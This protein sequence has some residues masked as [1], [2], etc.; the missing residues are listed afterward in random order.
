M[1]KIITRIIPYCSFILAIWF[2]I[3]FTGNICLASTE[4]P[5]KNET[6]SIKKVI[7]ACSSDSCKVSI[8]SL[9]FRKYKDNDFIH[10]R[11]YCEWI[12]QHF[13]NSKNYYTLSTVYYTKGEM[14]MQGQLFDS[15]VFCYKKALVF[16]DNQGKAKSYY[17]LGILSD[18][19]GRQE[20][21]LNY[22]KLANKYFT[23]INSS[24]NI[25][26][27]YDLI[28]AIYARRGDYETAIQYIKWKLELD[29]KTSNKRK[30]EEDNIY[31][32]F[33]YEQQNKFNLSF[34]YLHRAM[35][36]A[37][38]INDKDALIRIYENIANIFF[39]K[40][41]YKMAI[42]YHAKSLEKCGDGNY[43][44]EKA[45]IFNNLG[46]I[47]LTRG[48][49]RIAFLYIL[50]SFSI[51]KKLKDKLCLAN[52]YKNLGYFYKK[53]EKPDSAMF[54]FKLSYET[55]C[56]TRSKLDFYDVLIEIA[57]LYMF[58]RNFEQA[59]TWYM[60][61]LE[62][63]ENFNSKRDIALSKFKI[64]IYYQMRR[65]FPLAEKYYLQS[66]RDAQESKQ[67]SLIKNIADTLSNF[68][69]TKSNF[70]LAYKYLH[71]SQ[72]L[73]DSILKMDGKASMAAL[74][75]EFAFENLK[76]ENAA[77]QAL[78][79]EEIK[80]QKLFR[81]SLF[82]ISGL[83]VI[84][85]IIIF[86]N[87][88]K[89]RKDNHLLIIQ[90]NQ[91]AEKN[92]EILAKI[93]EIKIQKDEIERMSEKLHQTDQMK[94]RF[95]SNISHEIRTPLT[96]IINPLKNFIASFNGSLEQKRQL[97]VI[98][99]NA[100]R[101]HELTNQILDLQKLDS[102]NLSLSIENADI[103]SHLKGIVS[104][105]EGYCHKT[106]CTLKF[107]SQHSSICCPFDK[108]KITKILSNLL[109]N[110]FKYN[111]SGG[112]VNVLLSFGSNQLIISVQDSGV[113]IP[114]EYLN[115]IFKRYYQLGDSNV[116]HEGT[117]VGLAYVK[118]LV[119][120]M[121]GSIDINSKVNKGTIFTI[122]IPVAE[123]IINH[124]ENCEIIIKPQKQPAIDNPKYDIFTDENEEENVFVILITE[125]NEDLRNLIGDLFKVEYRVVYAK[126]GIEGTDK[127]VQYMPDI[128]ISDILMPQMD[129]LEMCSALKQNS[130]TSH[131]PIIL[132]TAKDSLESH[133]NGYQ[134]GA[135]D[136]MVKPFDST[137]LKLKVQ[138]MIETRE[139]V[140]KQFSFENLAD[141]GTPHYSE[142]DNDFIKKCISL[143][144]KNIDN[145][146]FSVDV[147]SDEMAFGRRSFFRKM[148]ALTNMSP[149]EFMMA[150]KLKYAANLLKGGLRVSEVAQSIGFE[151]TKS[152]SQAFKK[153]FGILP[154][155][156]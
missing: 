100:S 77:K 141:K 131:I 114:G 130:R 60:K 61:S 75:M 84:L 54:H 119:E 78:S 120:L 38:S 136:Y 104:S 33:L 80:R 26:G 142:M 125:D 19:L 28:V 44:Q 147:L 124:S 74:E 102:G 116:Q 110:A 146:D 72:I 30:E 65:L 50:R 123:I 48:N 103:V 108:D 32:A 99:D 95:F 151:N 41:N 71:L 133:I 89:K 13:K 101:L 132:L 57:D 69:L 150:Y 143:I 31:A 137:L 96:L 56:N 8:L 5:Y 138:N 68:Y 129:G 117:G 155:E 7:E 70:N 148:K 91:I 25:H 106:N 59:L 82:V 39:Q 126:N 76:K 17:K 4:H 97:D 87:Y 1:N 21:A 122:H 52:A 6:D 37:E 64:G 128:I 121:K 86:I 46:Q 88:R 118:E 94:L 42:E 53:A 98:H 154:S 85:G 2:V 112:E 23:I 3:L 83:F 49:D 73:G 140:K 113:G 55:G 66:I 43:D 144:N 93:E 135:D 153:Y 58:Q 67:P 45:N 10:A 15:A 127:A 35:K 18:Y 22:L 11:Y 27:T 14:L 111:N 92:Q 51:A 134:F 81:N 34:V 107:V 36:I 105:F 145:G 47:Y 109:S 63:A 16:S 90:K 115:D 149:Y 9:M 156:Y 29:R 12:Y 152:F 40:K 20:E 79:I 139:A 24:K 62:L